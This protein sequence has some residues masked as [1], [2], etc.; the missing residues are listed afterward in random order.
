MNRD[1]LAALFPGVLADGVLD[2]TRLAE[3][4]DVA[5]TAPADGRERFGLMWAG[6]QEAVRSLLTPSRGTLV[7]D[8]ERSIDFDNAKNVFIEGD[9]LEVLKLLQKSYN[10]KVKLIY[11]DPPYN[12]GNDFVYNDDFSDGLRGYLEY[13]GQVDEEGNRVSALSDTIGR[14]HSKWLSMM[15]PRLVLA[16]NLL[17]PDGLIAISID[18]NEVAHLRTLLDEIFGA[19]NYLNTFV[20]VS[21]LKGR[22]I[23]DG[24]A[25]GTH[26]Y[27][28]LYGRNAGLAEQLR[29]SFTA[30]KELMPSVYKGGGYELKSDEK[31]PYVTKNELYNTNSKFNELTAPTMIFRIHFNPSSAEVRVTDVDDDTTFPGFVTAMPH[32]NSRPNLSWHA[33]R[34]SRAKVLADSVDLEFKVDGDELRIWTKIRDVDGVA[35]KDLII[36]P[37]T[38]SGQADL[39]KLGL[40]RLF[41]TPKP[42]D[43]LKVLIGATTSGTDVVLDFFAGSGSTAHAVSAQNDSDGGVRTCVSVNLPEATPPESEAFKAGYLTVSAIT[44]AR[45]RKVLE[46]NPGA[47]KFGL[48]VLRLA[49]S[50]F[51]APEE[52]FSATDLFDL[53]ETTLRFGETDINSIATEVLLK[54][55]VALDS[56]WKRSPVNSGEIITAEQIAVVCARDLT[57]NVI[58]NAFEQKT[59]VVTFLED[60][61]IGQDTV[62]ANAFI[63]ARELGITMKTV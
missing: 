44:E 51:R 58:E 49:K 39:E 31:G 20:W 19:E 32:R 60:G 48:R 37:S 4:L 54:E 26:E 27:I 23:S 21:N 52:W 62:K 43:L 14:R 56:S 7:P 6:K 55:G 59:R 45:I 38:T 1:A 18:G 30:L 63:R 2:A 61:F 33:W 46:F 29:G 17:T 41:D 13:S 9:N 5:V 57:E 25:V 12:T 3:L 53:A 8:I 36:G 24:G 42:V 35:I 50:N 34:W 47:I 22:Q 40:K 11:I 16:R 28:L 10:D 15:Y